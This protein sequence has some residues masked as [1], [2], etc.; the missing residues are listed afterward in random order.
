M[1]P[2]IVS[3]ATP[4]PYQQE[5]SRLAES[6]R[7]FDVDIETHT[8]PEQGLW[9]Y[10]AAMKPAFLLQRMDDHPARPIVWVD[11][12]AQV[13]SK[14]VFFDELWENKFDVAAFHKIR[15]RGVRSGTVWLAPHR[16]TRRLVELWAQLTAENHGKKDHMTL[17]WAVHRMKDEL[18]IGRLPEGY[19]HIARTRS[20]VLGGD[21]NP[22]I[23][24]HQASRQLKGI[25]RHAPVDRITAPLR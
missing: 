8:M 1:K 11:A 15:K 16:V 17:T 14:P 6:C 20:R 5:M 7:K 9:R 23:I 24:H 25:E 21:G 3:F 10:N 4:G 2:L 12:D 18:K 22:V 13:V 19:C